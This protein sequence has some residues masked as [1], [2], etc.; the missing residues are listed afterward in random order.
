VDEDD[1]DAGTLKGTFRGTLLWEDFEDDEEDNGVYSEFTIIGETYEIKNGTMYHFGNFFSESAVNVDLTL[2][3]KDEDSWIYFEMFVPN[4][5]NRLVE[6]TYSPEFPAP[7]DDDYPPFT[8]SSGSVVLS[9]TDTS[10][11]VS[12]GTVEVSVSGSGNSAVYTIVIDCTL[13]VVV[14][15]SIYEDAGTL[16]G[17]YIGTLLWN[18]EV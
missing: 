13:V 16:E 9:D 6:G 7:P 17:T 3:T 4:G 5:N 10:Y 8:Y 14:G 2:S 18:D 1:E 12:G 15:E 11:Y